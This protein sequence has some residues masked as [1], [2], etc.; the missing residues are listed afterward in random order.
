MNRFKKVLGLGLFVALVGGVSAFAAVASVY[1]IPTGFMTP[2]TKWD[3]TSGGQAGGLVYLFLA[4][5][6]ETLKVGDV[7]YETANNS[8]GKS[9]TLVNYNTLAGVVVGGQNFSSVMGV[10]ND[11]SDV[12]S[13]ACTGTGKKCWVLTR[14]RAW[15]KTADS[16]YFGSQVIIGAVSGTIKRRST[17]IDTLNR[18]IGRTNF[19]IDSGKKVLL[20]VNIK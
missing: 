7:V 3:S 13:A 20:N 18:I 10:G 1:R 17:A 5:T 4:G 14:G 9:A 6:N 11:S 16:V 19:T 2:V 12:G 8:V 15:V